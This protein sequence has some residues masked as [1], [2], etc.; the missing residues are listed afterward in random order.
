MLRVIGYLR[1][2]GFVTTLSCHNPIINYDIRAPN[3]EIGTFG[4]D[5]IRHLV[6]IIEWYCKINISRGPKIFILN[7]SSILNIVTSSLS[8]VA[9]TKFI[10]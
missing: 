3:A 6:A 5:T 8:H 1:V 2:L 10:A 4:Y 7:L 9:Y